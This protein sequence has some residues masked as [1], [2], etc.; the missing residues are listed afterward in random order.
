MPSMPLLDDTFMLC[1]PADHPKVALEVVSAADLAGEALVMF[2][3]ELAPASH[4]QVLAILA[5]SGAQLAISHGARTWL[6]VLAMVSQGFGVS[7]VPKSLQKAGIS[8]VR[9]CR[10]DG[11]AMP[12]EGKLVWMPPV[13][14]LLLRRFLAIA[15]EVIGEQAKVSHSNYG[16]N[17]AVCGAE[18][19]SPGFCQ[20]PGRLLCETSSQCHASETSLTHHRY[21]AGLSPLRT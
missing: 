15:S 18:P 19:L 17:H 5:Q 4:D 21:D 1:L 20:P 11:L 7:L 3:R 13:E 16:I 10:F 9:F 12:V 14:S 2:A 8:N 6:T